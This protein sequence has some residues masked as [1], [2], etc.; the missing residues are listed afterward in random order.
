[1][2]KLLS[3]KI[4]EAGPDLKY[5][6]FDW[7]DN[8]VHMPTKI[9][10]LDE[11]GDEVMM[12]TS[13][14]ADYRE[15]IGKESFP[16]KGST[17]VGFAEDPFRYFSVKGDAQFMDDAL[18]A[19]TGP[20]WDDFREAINNGSIFAIIT[21][22]GHHPNTLKEAI[23]NYIQNNFGG[24]N[25]EVLIKNLK[26][27][28]DFV[29]EEDMSDEELIRSYLELNRYNPVSFGQEKSAASPEELKV[30]AMEDFVR[31][32]KSMAALLQKRAFLKKDIANNFIPS[33]GFSDD[34]ERNV[35]AMKKYFKGI[36]EPIK[37]YTTKG[38]TKKEY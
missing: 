13:D 20:A 31:Y 21:A 35:E 3:E 23:Y 18:E 38:G 26:K 6:A 16:Y 10:V 30:Q 28:R 25:R 22:R 34:D 29:G 11:D 17:V 1:M 24:I 33:I 36:K 32:V 27:Y 9:V 8:I 7:D 12:S 4:T 19:Q 2:K 15:K 37:T 5:Y 14:F